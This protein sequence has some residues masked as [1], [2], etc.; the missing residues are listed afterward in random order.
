MARQ[1]RTSQELPIQFPKLDYTFA[2]FFCGCGGFS[3]GFIQAGLK[4][5]SAMDISPEA[6]ATYWYNLCYKTWSH[7]W[8]DQNNTKAINAIRKWSNNGETQNFL[9]PKGVPDNW[10]EVP[11]PMPCLNLFCY[12]ILDIEPEEWM[13]YCGVRPGDIKIFIG[14]PPCQGFSMANEKRSVYD[15]RNQLPLRYLY[16]AKVAKPDYVLVEN[17]PGLLS[18]GKKKGEKEGPFVRWIR[19]AFDDAGYDME[20]AVHNAADYG[21]PQNRH[22]VI[23][24]GIRKG[25]T[26]WSLPEGWYGEGPGKI[27]YQTVMEAIG[28]LPPIRA[29]EQWGKDVLHP[30]GLN[31]MDGY[32]ICPRCLQY[33]REERASCVH[34]GFPLD[35]PIN[36]GVV[37][38]PGFGT[39]VDTKKPVDN[40]MMRKYSLLFNIKD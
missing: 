8:V 13:E 18:L 17:V 24:L 19:E 23:F 37:R 25:V 4:C 10:L 7:L 5:I 29:G 21:V 16:Y 28:H 1:N 39:L 12:S 40:E 34:C 26:K 32:V 15:E 14:G 35:Q 22:R 33:N 3:L 31:K 38:V 9:F 2:D 20:Y 30:Y 36:G 6:L 11:E 27:P